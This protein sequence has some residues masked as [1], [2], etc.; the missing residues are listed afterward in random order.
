[1]SP[2]TTNNQSV[3]DTPSAEQNFLICE[4]LLQARAADK[5]QIPLF[6]FPKTE[7]G[8]IDYAEYTGRDIDRCVDHAAKYYMQCG[9]Q[10][11]SPKILMSSLQN[12]AYILPQ[13]DGSQGEPQVIALLAAT[14][15]TYIITFFALARLGYTALCLSP[16]LAPNACVK[17][18]EDTGAI[19][20]IPGKTAQMANLISQI[21]ELL[22]ESIKV[23]K[24][25]PQD[26]FDKSASAE[27]RFRRENID[28][29]LEKHWCA[30]ILHSSGTTGLP[31]AIHLPHK[32]LMMHVPAPKGD[33]NFSTFP[34]FH[35]YGI[36]IFVHDMLDRKTTYM[37]NANLPTTADYVIKVLEHI[38]PD[39]LHAVP[40]T[41]E[42]LAQSKRGV[43]AMKKCDRVV[44]S[45]SGCPDDLGND[46]VKKGIL[47]E[48]LWGATEMGSLGTS[49]NRELGDDSWDYIRMPPPVAKH[50]YMKPLGDGTYECVFLHG[51]PA[52][53]VSNSNDPPKS[54]HS[55]DIFLKHPKMEAWKH[56]GRL[57]DRLTLING[58]K[59]LPVPMEG[60]IRQDPLIKEC[61]VFGTGKSIPG[62]FVFRNDDSQNLTD[63]EFID[64]IWPTIQKANAHA[65]S[66]AQIS[67][68]TIVS[69]SADVDYAKTDKMSIKRAQIYRQFSKEMEA[70]YERLEYA[71]TGML[72]LDVSELEEWLVQT[73]KEALSVQ[74]ASNEDDFFAAGV[75]SL[76]AIQMRGLI[77]KDLDLGG[78]SR[79][80]SPNIV[81]DTGNVT[82]LAKHLYALRLNETIREDEGDEIHEM[83]AMI[84][85][86]S[87]FKNHIPGSDPVPERHIVVLTG[88]TGSLGAH[89]LSQ[90]LTHPD[91][92]YVYCLVRGENPQA[93]VLQALQQRRLPVTNPTRLIALTGDLSQAELG[94]SPEIYQLLLF[95]VTTI[96]HSAWAVNFNLGI[97]SFEAQHIVGVHNLLQLSLSV[98]T[99]HPARFFFCS[100]VAAAV[101]TP[102]PA[103]IPE[104][105]MHDL[106]AALPQGYARSKLVSEH[107]VRNASLN[108]GALTRILRIGQIV[109]DGKVGLW[110]DTEAVP[111]MIRS[112][113][114]LKALPALDGTESWLPVDTLASTI[115]ELSGITTAQSPASDDFSDLVYNLEN[116]HTFSWTDDLLPELARSGLEFE[117]VSVF[118]WLQRLRQYER[119]G[120]NPESNPAVK[121]LGH[122]ERMYGTKEQSVEELKF[123]ISTAEKHSRSLREAPRLV[124]DGYVRKFVARWLEKWEGEGQGMGVET[125]G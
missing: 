56:I 67:K 47:L 116:P 85:K 117:T 10:P 78:N 29:E 102:A 72:K 105:P 66:F 71:G 69:V 19:A 98:S 101:G 74:L 28:R 125:S 54:F 119:D 92:H 95:Q 40:Y 88:A 121:L 3:Q 51:L 55:K 49:F 42:L 79:K 24:Q 89:L 5:T 103:I 113:L 58:E 63:A 16:R 99:S 82:R 41:I 38:R 14:D 37:Y 31:K 57:D 52:L 44:F 75:N 34:F 81:F 110:N 61:C 84:E 64:A 4:D 20:V 109:G 23:I 114:T 124:Q 36:W 30:V 91:V 2:I 118:D 8:T 115:L 120:G 26:N 27:P 73:F 45:G 43:D 90:L 13:K 46:L 123:D 35:G 65:E 80:V 1:M 122:F 112:A 25:I 83:E 108:A 76:Q 53:V 86:Y 106:K 18:M 33:I 21:Q 68:E 17:L 111:L 94:L 22:S 104:A 39:V 59:V 15:L 60:R 7:R 50:I 100:S 12:L 11:V 93:R 9:L 32:R 62:V 48:S 70:M 97:K 77:M 107:I 6:C 96:V 87:T